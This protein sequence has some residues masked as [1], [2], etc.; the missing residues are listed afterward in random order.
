MGWLS[1]HLKKNAYQDITIISIIAAHFLNNYE[2]LKSK[3]VNTQGKLD[4]IS[5]D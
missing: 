2:E 4:L 5:L 1:R 3:E